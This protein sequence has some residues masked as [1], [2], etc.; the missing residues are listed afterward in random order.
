VAGAECPNRMLNCPTPLRCL[1]QRAI[2]PRGSGDS[3]DL[4][5][6]LFSIGFFTKRQH[7]PSTAGNQVG[8]RV[9]GRLRGKGG[10]SARFSRLGTHT[11]SLQWLVWTMGKWRLWP[12]E[13]TEA[14][15][16]LTGRKRPPRTSCSMSCWTPM[17]QVES[18]NET[19]RVAN[20]ISHVFRCPPVPPHGPNGY[21]WVILHLADQNGGF[22]MS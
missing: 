13:V 18:S 19:R 17:R 22:G 16:S 1:S 8:R 6:N 14:Y 12:S 2:F 21:F 4:L 11:T 20:G 9:S 7:L 5:R 10:S 15:G 3:A